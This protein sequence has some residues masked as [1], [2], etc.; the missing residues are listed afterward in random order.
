MDKNIL[1]DHFSFLLGK[2]IQQAKLMVGDTYY[3]RII[4]R[5]GIDK[6]LDGRYIENR[7]NVE[8]ENTKIVNILNMG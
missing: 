1:N 3:V 6:R 4:K 7:I 2:T 8:I 5:D